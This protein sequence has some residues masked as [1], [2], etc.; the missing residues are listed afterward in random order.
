MDNETVPGDKWDPDQYSKFAVE[1]SKPFFDLLALVEPVPGG[2]VIDLGC[3]TGELTARLHERTGA[4][5]TVGVDSSEAML[6]KARPF[7]GNGLSFASGD[8]AD[9]DAEARFDVVFANASLHWVPDHPRLLRRLA[10]GLRPGGQLAV[11][12]PANADHPSHALADE[13]AREPRFAEYLRDDPSI[14]SPVCRPEEY[15]EL[16]YEIGFSK[17][18]VRLQVYG[19]ELAATTDVAEWTKGTTLL[20]FQR[21]LPTEL[22]GQFLDSY[23]RRLNEVLGDQSPYFYTFKRILIWARLSADAAPGRAGNR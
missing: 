21:L 18:Q 2:D 5:T 19:H 23:R 13:V 20:R 3:G 8:I 12:V 22:F 17:Q 15:A 11:Q 1:R 14:S 9:F 16:C 6:E 4:A 10:A 7:A